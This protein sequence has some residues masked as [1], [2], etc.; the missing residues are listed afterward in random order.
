M[1]DDARGAG[2]R[3][4]ATLVGGR[5][6][7][8][9]VILASFFLLPPMFRA[10]NYRNNFHWPPDEPPSI[11]SAWKTW[12]AQ[13]YLYLSQHPY[14]PGHVSVALYPLWPWLIGAGSRLLGGQTLLAALLLAGALATAAAL[15]FHRMAERKLGR[16]AAG[17]ALVMLL[18]QPAA[19]YLGL[20]YAEALFLLLALLV[21]DRLEQGRIL[22]AGVVAALLP[23]ARPP[24]V[25]IVF[26][27]AVAV[28]LRW[29]AERRLRAGDA[30]A[31][32]LP[33]LGA[34]AHATLM[35]SQTGDPFASITIQSI[36]MG[37]GSLLRLLDPVRVI[38]ELV[39]VGGLHTPRSSLIDRAFF[40]AF[41]ATLPA[42]ARLGP[43]QLA[44]AIPMGLFTGVAQG[45][46]TCF[47]RYLSVVFP[48]FL[49]W[50]KGLADPRASWWRPLLVLAFGALQLLLML[51][52]AN[53]FYVA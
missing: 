50:G 32:A 13:H 16:G 41:L 11:V 39:T 42:I 24:G 4:A 34:G 44:Y 8:H 27:I 3:L 45:G 47:I 29:R 10:D 46:F 49:A 30:I 21:V 43:I 25:F 19:F 15:L 51:L 12:D 40:L 53:N 38:G 9:L 7:Q 31:V 2:R 20:P 52:H 5:L 22:E 33:L 17:W 28:V 26:P 23:L 18:A 35:W 6:L 37:Q 1:S 48:V 36:Y 14:E